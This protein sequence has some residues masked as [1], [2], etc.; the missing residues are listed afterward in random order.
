MTQCWGNP[1]T[2]GYPGGGKRSNK[3]A[4]RRRFVADGLMVP[5]KTVVPIAIRQISTILTAL[6]QNRLVVFA[7]FCFL[8]Q[9]ITVA[10]HILEHRRIHGRLRAFHTEKAPVV[11]QRRLAKSSFFR[12]GQ[13]QIPAHL[14][15]FSYRKGPHPV[16]L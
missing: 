11:T 7:L 10:N 13:H 1:S 14:D 15:K 6:G 8:G 16:N 3:G 12:C 9:P 2:G 5:A 4:K